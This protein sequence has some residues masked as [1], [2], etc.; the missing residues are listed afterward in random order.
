MSA[1]R[2]DVDTAAPAPHG[3]RSSLDLYAAFALRGYRRHATYRTATLVGLATNVVFGFLRSYVFLALYHQRP[4]VGGY[5]VAQALS[6]V[7]LTQALIMVV[8]VW[9][10]TEL[11]RKV[12][13]GDIVIDLVRPVNM[14]TTM[15]ASDL[16][17]GA[18][19]LLTRAAVPVVVGALAFGIAAPS[20]P[21]R[22]LAVL[23]SV[24]LA[25]LVSYCFRFLYN[26]A[27][28]WLL[29]YRG[30]ALMAI[31]AANF[32]SGFVVP[33]NYFPHWLRI[34]ALATPFPAMVQTPI[35]IFVSHLDTSA[36]VVALGTQAA[37]VIGLTALAGLALTAGVRRAVV[38]GG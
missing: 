30:P 16:G 32:F 13:T 26:V 2:A 27:A 18:Y 6:Y 23:L 37:W 38:Q 17:R 35:D 1:Q 28:F 8:H 22:W 21:G 25:V 20:T 11:A 5:S 4:S 36:T 7:W 31:L 15:L 33:V 29:D 9:A 12:R 34:V 19:Y 14:F 3:G 10:W 24:L